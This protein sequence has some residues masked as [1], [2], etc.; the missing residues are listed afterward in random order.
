[1]EFIPQMAVE[2]P[3]Q[4]ILAD[5]LVRHHIVQTC[6]ALPNCRLHGLGQL[7]G[8]LACP[9]R[10]GITADL[11]LLLHEPIEQANPPG[12]QVGADDGVAQRDIFAILK[13]A[14]GFGPIVRAKRKS[15][16]AWK[17]IF[18]VRISWVFGLGGNNFAK[19][20]PDYHISA[21]ISGR[22]ESTII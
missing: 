22:S 15:F 3:E 14:Q 19:T 6:S 16:P 13:L 5:G 18:I 12:I 20:I 2:K 21:L 10:A 1:M 4:I 9:H 8:C 17:S 7:Q 11:S